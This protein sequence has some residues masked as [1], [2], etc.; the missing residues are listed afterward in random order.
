MAERIDPRLNGVFKIVTLRTAINVCDALVDAGLILKKDG[1]YVPNKMD[2]DG[3]NAMLNGVHSGVKAAFQNT[4]VIAPAGYGLDEIELTA[5]MVD[6]QGRARVMCIGN[7]V[8]VGFDGKKRMFRSVVSPMTANSNPDIKN[9]VAGVA[10][11]VTVRGNGRLRDF[12]L[13]LNNK[14]SQ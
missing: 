11:K 7:A 6:G 9:K 13:N 14:K 12:D 4:K 5:S 2:E 1:D 3:L 8:G 10:K